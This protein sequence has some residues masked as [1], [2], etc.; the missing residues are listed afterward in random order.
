MDVCPNFFCVCVCVVWVDL[1]PPS[2]ET[3][4]LS[5]NET[6][7]LENSMSWTIFVCHVIKDGEEKREDGIGEPQNC[8]ID[9]LIFTIDL[10][11]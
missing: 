6:Q 11:M 4:Q 10:K 7:I 9:F 2:E 8:V 1:H 5:L 3:Y